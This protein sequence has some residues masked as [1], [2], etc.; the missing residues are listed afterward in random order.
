MTWLN[1]ALTAGFSDEIGGGVCLMISARISS[2]LAPPNGRRRVR[3][4][5]HTT[6]KENTSVAA[7]TGFALE[8]F[9][10]MQA[11]CPWP[12]LFSWRHLWGPKSLTNVF[13][14]KDVAGL[15]VA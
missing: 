10:A 3:A 6:P 7:V 11:E 12:Q 4:S 13:Q 14:N 15:D 8:L 2:G 9:G 5:K 1:A